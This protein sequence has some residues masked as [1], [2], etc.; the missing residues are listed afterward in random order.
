MA[1]YYNTKLKGLMGQWG[2][3]MGIE[4]HFFGETGYN[5]FTL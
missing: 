5:S 3:G 1:R 2:M 4:L